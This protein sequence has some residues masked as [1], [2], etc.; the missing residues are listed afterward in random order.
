MSIE[1]AFGW[2]R[3]RTRDRGVRSADQERLVDLEV[4]LSCSWPGMMVLLR[5]APRASTAGACSSFCCCPPAEG[6][7]G[8]TLGG[9]VEGG[10]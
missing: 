7:G 4:A 1:G 3:G 9:G 10:G 8:G 6:R 5:P 2:L